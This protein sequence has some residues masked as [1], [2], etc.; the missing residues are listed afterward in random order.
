MA[1]RQKWIEFFSTVFGA[2][3]AALLIPHASGVLL[4]LIIIAVALYRLLRDLL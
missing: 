4:M 3:I 2:F 1:A